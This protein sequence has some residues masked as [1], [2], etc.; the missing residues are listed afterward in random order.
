MQT[1]V[2]FNLTEQDYLDF[3]IFWLRTSKYI[4]KTLRILRIV[5]AL[6]LLSLPLLFINKEGKGISVFDVLFFSIVALLF[7]IFIPKLHTALTLWQLKKMIAGKR[8]SILG[9]Q[10][11]TIQEEGIRKSSSSGESFVFYNTF[12]DMKQSDKAIYLFTGPAI[13]III[14]FHAF[15]SEKERKEL[16]EFLQRKVIASEII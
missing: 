12:I 16:A 14:P 4:R 13:A 1:I 10:T 5:A 3:S 7:F 6:L 9:N 11:I 15:S 8:N 2:T